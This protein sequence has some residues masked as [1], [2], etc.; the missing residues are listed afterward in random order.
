MVNTCGLTRLIALGWLVGF[1][2][3]TMTGSSAAGW[4]TALVTVAIVIG[5]QR[6]RGGGA[7]CPI[8]TPAEEHADRLTPA[9]V[10]QS[11]R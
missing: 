6:V 4:V 1:G 8:P 2:V 3:A 10:P 11:S 9:E 5:V 7:A